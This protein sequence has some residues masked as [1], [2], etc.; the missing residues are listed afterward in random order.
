[1]ARASI[2]A[3]RPTAAAE[4]DNLPRAQAKGQ[5]TKAAIIDA[6]LRMAAQVGLEGLSIGALAEAMSMS[7][8]GVF[9]HFGSREELQISVVR[10]YY[11]RFEQEVFA[12]AMGLSR[13]LPRLRAL[14]EHWMRFTSAELDSGCIFISGAVEFD[15]RPG[16]VRDAL[17]AA[18]GAWLDAI[19][20]AIV[21]AREEG[22]FPPKADERQIAFE[23]HALILA[24]HYEARFLQRSGSTERA[25]RGFDNVLTRHGA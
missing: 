9:A 13:G 1:M 3:L 16:A 17:V 20:R 7:K 10:E 8:S 21:Q 25:L 12:P 4:G 19:T 24:L 22:H 15:D 2:I 6:A 11:A 23:I 5:Q 14:F 18:V